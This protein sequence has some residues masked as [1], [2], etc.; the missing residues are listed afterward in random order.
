MMPALARLLGPQPDTIPQ[1]P[2]LEPDCTCPAFDP[3]G[4][5]PTCPTHPWWANDTPVLQLADH[6]DGPWA[7][8][9]E[10]FGGGA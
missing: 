6:P 1:P 10:T 9:L 3:P 8:A 5:N 4:Q 7:A 2:D